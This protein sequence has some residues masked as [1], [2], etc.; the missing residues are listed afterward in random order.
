MYWYYNFGDI[1]RDYVENS[2]IC[3]N[4]DELYYTDIES[5]TFKKCVDFH[6]NVELCFDECADRTY[7]ALM[8]Y[9]FFRRGGI[10]F[11]KCFIL[12]DLISNQCTIF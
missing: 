6:E 5:E 10:N 9:N 3:I 11:C 2:S 7:E 4:P 8:K 12:S 1:I